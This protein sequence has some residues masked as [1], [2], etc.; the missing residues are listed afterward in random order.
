VPIGA[1]AFSNSPR[2]PVR[3]LL[4]RFNT[5]ILPQTMEKFEGTFKE[6]VP[7]SA[8]EYTFLD[9]NLE[10]LYASEQ[11]TARVGLIFS[12]LAIFVACLGL[13]GLAAFTAEQR[14]K[15]IGVRKVLGASV[16]N[17]TQLLSKDFI[18][19]VLFSLVIA[20][21]IALWLMEKWLQDFAYR[22]ELGWLVFLVA[23]ILAIVIAL[24][25]VSFQATKAAMANP[26]K[27]LRTE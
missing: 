18:L 21:P 3:T 1:Y 2:E 9:K 10:T 12:I 13:F 22:I 6:V 4:V 16:F 5:G 25:T 8:F 15:E 14:R 7:D 20:F 24:V 23:G 19:L 27:S 17:I 26:V 11:R